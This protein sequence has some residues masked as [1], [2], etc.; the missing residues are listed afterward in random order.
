LHPAPLIPVV[1]EVVPV[2]FEQ[3]DPGPQSPDHSGGPA[4]PGALET[5]PVEGRNEEDE[6]A[7]TGQV[8]ADAVL[9]P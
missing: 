4:S 1:L 7:R 5:P 3:L 8:G 9:V 2:V 6:E